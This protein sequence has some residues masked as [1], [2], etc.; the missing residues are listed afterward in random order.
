MSDDRRSVSWLEQLKKLFSNQ[1]DHLTQL[2]E[3]L[4]KSKEENLIDA[5][6]LFMIEGVLE[7]SEMR[8]RDAMIPRNQM[9][10]VDDSSS[11]EIILTLMLKASHSRYPVISSD[12]NEANSVKGVLLAKDVLKAVV[13]NQLTSK[14]DLEVLYRPAIIVP[15]SKRLNVLLREFKS[16]RNHMAIVVDEYGELSGVITI[17]DVLEEIVGDISDEHDEDETDNI[18]KHVK[19]GYTVDAI[20]QVDEFNEF[21]KTDIENGQIETVG[22][23]VNHFLGRIPEKDEVFEMAGLIFEVT[24]SSQRRADSFKVN[25]VGKEKVSEEMKFSNSKKEV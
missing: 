15:E 25:P 13:N 16:G 9:S 14:E 1:A 18:Q 17:E 19:G 11:L 8:V 10:S 21:F 22:G 6:A 24:K 5:D 3:L 4:K 20:T 7:V 12:G 2:A 23:A